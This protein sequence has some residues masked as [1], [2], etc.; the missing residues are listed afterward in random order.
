MLALIDGDIVVYRCGWA[1]E[2]ETETIACVRTDDCIK[3][4]LNEVGATSY[5]VWFSDSLENNYRLRYNPEY[6]A[7]RALQPKPR[8]Y[9]GL[10]L[11][12]QNEWK[13]QVT[14]NQEADDILGIM[15]SQAGAGETIICSIDKDLLQ[16]PG[17][18][19]NF[20]KKEFI[21]QDYT[22]GLRHFYTQCLVGDRVDNIFGV[23]GIGPVKA[24]RAFEGLSSELDL[25]EKTLSLYDSPARLENNGICLWVRRKPDE[26]WK[27]PIETEL[28]DKSGEH[29]DPAHGHSD[30]GENASGSVLLGE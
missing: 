20:V 17:L 27:F 5:Q 3:R 7:N 6:K 9:S 1:A 22:N 8:H 2:N 25:F 23:A 14:T 29:S 10:K 4:I 13:A 18:H 30:G 12:L 19:Y 26:I 15:Q 11:F 24:E 21:E 16:V 28:Q